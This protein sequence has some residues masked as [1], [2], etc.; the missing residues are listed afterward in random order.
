MIQNN[1]LTHALG[2][3]A[4][5]ISERAELVRAN[6]YDPQMLVDALSNINYQLL[7]CIDPDE[8]EKQQ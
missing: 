8:L 5:V 4:M 7:A 6:D 1:E 3:L 2:I